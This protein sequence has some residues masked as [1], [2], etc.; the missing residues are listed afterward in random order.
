M[1]QQ[2]ATAISSM[3][4]YTQ[5]TIN[6]LQAKKEISTSKIN[7]ILV[8]AMADY[9]SSTTIGETYQAQKRLEKNL[10]ANKEDEVLQSAEDSY[11]KD[12]TEDVD[13][14]TDISS[15]PKEESKYLEATKQSFAINNQVDNAA[16]S[17]LSGSLSTLLEAAGGIGV[18]S[19]NATPTMSKKEIEDYIK[20]YGA[21]KLVDSLN[22]E[23]KRELK[24]TNEQEK[25]GQIESAYGEGAAPN[26]FGSDVMATKTVCVNSVS[27]VVA[28]EAMSTAVVSYSGGTTQRQAPEGH[29][30]DAPRKQKS[31]GSSIDIVV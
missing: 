13:E 18:T 15:A 20:R 26:E 12:A 28:V 6:A 23:H 1:K 16:N 10:K 8:G 30:S 2:P 3:S 14:N 29:D 17:K 31:E 25:E 22:E 4:K 11:L 27:S 5:A 7:T 19:A 24:N 9:A 21:R